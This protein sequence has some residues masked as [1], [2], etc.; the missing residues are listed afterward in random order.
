[1]V[2]ICRIIREGDHGQI[3]KNYHQEKMSGNTL[4]QNTRKNASHWIGVSL[5]DAGDIKLPGVINKRLV[6]YEVSVTIIRHV[7]PHS[8]TCK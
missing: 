1:M 3:D 7:K 4:T 2:L 8:R 5:L 6:D